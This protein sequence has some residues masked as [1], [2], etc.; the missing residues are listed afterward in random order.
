[1]D[2]AAATVSPDGSRVFAGA[3]DGWIR[4]FRAN[5]G[6]LLWKLD[7]GERV[8]AA[9]TLAGKS[10]YVASYSGRVYR[11][12]ALSGQLRWEYDTA[13]PILSS[14]AVAG[15]RLFVSNDKNTIFALEAKSGKF[16][17]KKSRPHVGEF[18]VTGQSGV[19]LVDGLAITGFS[20]GN[21]VAM[22]AEDG[23]TAWSRYLG[24]P[25]RRL[26]DI[27]ETPVVS[28]GVVFAAAFRGGLHAM[29]PKTGDIRWRH[30]VEGAKGPA[31][32]R[33]SLFISTADREVRCLDR[34]SG[35]LQWVTQLPEGSLSRPVVSGNWLFVATDHYLAVLSAASGEILRY[36]PTV[37][38]ISA[39]PAVLKGR[40]YTVTNGGHLLAFQVLR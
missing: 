8:E 19:A 15:D 10:L 34:A 13:A 20:D 5:D 12:D 32:Q 7:T 33:T 1:M 22:A 6:E 2:A 17:W 35:A 26:V 25:S 11:L 23:A 3:A 27:D 31:V 39:I 30:A 21:L 14:P 28:E 24:E 9:P 18:T 36:W 29:D 38:G 16:L 37:D 4:S 40:A